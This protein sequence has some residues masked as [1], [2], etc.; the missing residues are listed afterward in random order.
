MKAVMDR[1]PEQNQNC[2]NLDNMTKYE[3]FHMHGTDVLSC[4]E[5]DGGGKSNF[6]FYQHTILLMID[7]IRSFKLTKNSTIKIIN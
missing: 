2:S 3:Q 4:Q 5:I 1:R 7:R 6:E